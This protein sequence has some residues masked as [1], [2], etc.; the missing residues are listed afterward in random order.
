M[1]KERTRDVEMWE[2]QDVEMVEIREWQDEEMREDVEMRKCGNAGNAGSGNAWIQRWPDYN[3]K[4]SRAVLEAKRHAS[5]QAHIPSFP[6]LHINFPT[7]TFNLLI[8][9]IFLTFAAP[10]RETCRDAAGT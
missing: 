4:G 8:I 5:G 10:F 3:D 2:W 1:V 6:H 9:S 7:S